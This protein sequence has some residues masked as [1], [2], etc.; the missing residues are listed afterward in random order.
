[1]R[2]LLTLEYLQLLLVINIRDSLYQE[3]AEI[4][5]QSCQHARTEG[6]FY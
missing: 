5:V 1:M 3:T 6:I 2:E 4:P